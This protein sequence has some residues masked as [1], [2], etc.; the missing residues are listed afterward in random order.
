M[1]IFNPLPDD[2]K[3]DV[4]TSIYYRLAEM[5]LEVVEQDFI[6]PWGGFF[7]IAE[8]SIEQFITHFFPEHLYEEIAQGMS[9]TPKILVVGPDHRLSWQYHDRRAEMWSVLSGPVGMITSDTDEQG[10]VQTLQTGDVVSHDAGVRHRLCGLDNYG[11]VAEFWQHL[12][13]HNPSDEADIVRLA[14]DYA[15]G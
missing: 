5:G 11:I 15:R 4:A 2:H 9:L 6:R 8:K 10:P 1:A 13:P 12:H 7:V 14:D 3:H